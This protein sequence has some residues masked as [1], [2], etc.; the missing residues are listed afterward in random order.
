MQKS[1]LKRSDLK[2]GW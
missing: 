2:T 1:N